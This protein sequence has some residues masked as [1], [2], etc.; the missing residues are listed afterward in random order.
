MCAALTNQDAAAG[1]NLAAKALDAQPLALRIAS[2]CRRSAAL[3]VCHENLKAS[4]AARRALCKL[5]VDFD[6]RQ[7]LPMAALNFILPTALEFQNLHFGA[8][9]VPQDRAGHPRLGC[10]IATENFLSIGAN[11]EDLVELYLSADL[12]L[13]ALNLDDFAWCD[14]ILFS[15]TTD[16]GVHAA[17][18]PN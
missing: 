17:S 5:N 1:Y 4:R 11:C 18:Q 12:A 15:P 2:V 6:G 10:L 13:E 14:A 7:T 3:F 8:A 9:N 16:Y